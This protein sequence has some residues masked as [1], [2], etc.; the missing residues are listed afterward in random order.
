M[1]DYYICFL[2]FEATCD[3]IKEL[4][5][6]EIIEFPSVLYHWDTSDNKFELVDEFQ[7]Y[8]KPKHNPTLSAFCKNLTGITQEQ[9]DE[10]G[11]FLDVFQ[12]HYNWL[13]S[14]IP[15]GALASHTLMV[16]CGNWDLL[17]MLP[18]DC[19]RHW[20]A[21]YPKIYQKFINIKT[22][23]QRVLNTPKQYGL[24][25][26]I[27]Y[28]GLTFVGRAHSGIVDSRNMVTLFQYLLDNGYQLDLNLDVRYVEYRPK[29]KKKRQYV[30]IS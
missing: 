24:G 23:Y 22:I 11:D 2:D 7:Q 9:V 19:R 28:T 25:R 17:T 26:M 16:T 27:E 12:N 8:V 14:K 15:Y 4:N 3:E 21:N 1:T 29:N 5:N 13:K 6:H 18:K 30:T 10:G 20:V